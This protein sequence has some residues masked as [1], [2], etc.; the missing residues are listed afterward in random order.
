MSQHQP[1]IK[2][3]TA[4]VNITP[5]EPVSMG[6]YG[7]RA[8]LVSRGVHDPLWAKALYVEN[9][10][11]RLL[12]ISADLISIPNTL[13][14]QVSNALVEKGLVTESEL[15]L[16]ASHTHSGPDVDESIVIAAP[17][18]PYLAQLAQNLVQV[19]AEACAHL[20]P[21]RIKRAVGQVDFL[22]NRRQ[23][24]EKGLVDR[25]FLA[26]QLDRLADERPLAVLFGLGCH[27]VCLGH[28]NLAISAD[29][30]GY[31]QRFIEAQLGVENALFVNLAEGNILPDSRPLYD[32]LDTRGYLGGTFEDADRIGTAL[33]QAVLDSLSAV[34]PTSAVS[35][36][37]RKTTLQVKPAHHDLGTWAALRLL[38]AK[39]KIILEYLP[40]FRKASPFHLEPVFTLWRD[41]SRVVIEQDMSEA[42]MRRLMSAVSSF[43]VM[44]MKLT[45][46]AYRRSTPL[47]IQTITLGNYHL[48]TL[49][50]EVLVEVSRDWQRLNT[51]HPEQAFVIGLANGYL[52][53][54][55]HPD[56]FQEV[57]AEY[58]YETIMNALEPQATRL[59][60]E[61]AAKMIITDPRS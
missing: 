30:P 42:E 35:M 24:Q 50:G 56:N 58:K 26:L 45:N 36:R 32:S 5:A 51:Q 4:R 55:P 12:L 21:V 37:V 59:A 47:V 53:Y 48:L 15:C 10:Q 6:G 16:A 43:L 39:R 44:A 13:Y 40:S 29:Y 61:Q 31:A 27:P 25:R 46:P 38:L 20:S 9:G 60:L 14:Q 18:R 41:A 57:N 2:A 49:P 54:L 1:G 33:A 34:Q 23:R 11:E 3:G 52:G 28:D 8:G 17:N 22:V 19:G 7:Q